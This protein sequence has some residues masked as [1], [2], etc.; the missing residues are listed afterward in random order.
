MDDDLPSDVEATEGT[1]FND[2]SWIVGLPRVDRKCLIVRHIHVGS[3][4]VQE[5]EPGP[6]ESFLVNAGEETSKILVD[7]NEIGVDRRG[8]KD[9]QK[10]VDIS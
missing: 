10:C 6:Y 1:T 5:H 2:V 3:K 4:E 8:L 7:Q 9:G